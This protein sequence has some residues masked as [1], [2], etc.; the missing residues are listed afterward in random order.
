MAP[1]H[2]LFEVI[3]GEEQDGAIAIQ[4]GFSIVEALLDILP[5]HNTLT[6]LGAVAGEDGDDFRGRL[7][8]ECLVI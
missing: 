1:K 5:A 8:L 7:D 4:D 3:I 2:L 6:R